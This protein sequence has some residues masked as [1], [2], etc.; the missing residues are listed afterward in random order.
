MRFP[1]RFIPAVLFVLLVSDG[2]MAQN[3]YNVTCWGGSKLASCCWVAFGDS[4]TR[5]SFHSS[6]VV[7]R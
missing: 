7:Q 5:A 2:V 6:V 1:M 4:F 3:I